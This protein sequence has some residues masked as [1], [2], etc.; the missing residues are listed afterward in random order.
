MDQYKIEKLSKGAPDDY[1]ECIFQLETIGENEASRS[2]LLEFGKKSKNREAA[3]KL[4][5]TIE[6][7]EKIGVVAAIN[8]ETI[9][10]LSGNMY[11]IRIN[12][13]TIRA[14]CHGTNENKMLVIVGVEGETHRG[15]STNSQN[16]IN[17]YRDKIEIV[18]NLLSEKKGVNNE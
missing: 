10:H 1:Y 17:K 6:H 2:P 13:T 7:I 12:R 5:N 15:G 8:K 4:L 18:E 9:K 16:F 14:Y 11:E 3:N